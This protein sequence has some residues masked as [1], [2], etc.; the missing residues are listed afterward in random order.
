MSSR[1]MLQAKADPTALALL[2]EVASFDFA[3]HDEPAPLN[4]SHPFLTHVYTSHDARSALGCHVP[5]KASNSLS[6][7]SVIFCHSP[8]LLCFLLTRKGSM[9]TIVK[10][11]FQRPP[12]LPPTN[13][14]FWGGDATCGCEYLQFY[15]PKPTIPC[16]TN[17]KDIIYLL[18]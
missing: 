2:R 10:G 18:T 7:K 15:I 12:C 14:F 13:G 11:I 4:I 5:A 17:T 8:A 16:Y 6:A 3:G 9:K 1:R